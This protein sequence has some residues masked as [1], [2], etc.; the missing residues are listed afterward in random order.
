MPRGVGRHG[1]VCEGKA[2][3]VSLAPAHF[4]DGHL[5]ASLTV[6]NPCSLDDLAHF[7]DVWP[8]LRQRVTLSVGYDQNSFA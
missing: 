8:S 2:G 6:R 7:W 3:E 1:D 4:L 5:L